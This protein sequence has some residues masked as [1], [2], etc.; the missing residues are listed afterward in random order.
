MRLGIGSPCSDSAGKPLAFIDKLRK[1]SLFVSDDLAKF[2]SSTI[3][4]EEYEAAHKTGLSGPRFELVP[5][6]SLVAID[7]LWSLQGM[8]KPFQA[9]KEFADVVQ[10]GMRYPVPDLPEYPRTPMPRTRHLYVG[11]HWEQR[12]GA[13]L[14]LRNP[15]LELVNDSDNVGG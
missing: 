14:G 4:V 13:T 1:R 9:I 11:Q 5:L 3:D 10:N 8:H 6:Q 15:I 2:T 12:Y 7:C